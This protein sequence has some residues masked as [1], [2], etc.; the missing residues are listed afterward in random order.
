MVFAWFTAQRPAIST[1]L[2]AL[3]QVSQRILR[4]D[5]GLREGLVGTMIAA[6]S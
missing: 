4:M 6:G 5:N 2:A 3:R 1:D